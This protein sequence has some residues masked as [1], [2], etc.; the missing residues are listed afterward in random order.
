MI[1]EKK[2][3]RFGNDFIVNTSTSKVECKTI[4]EFITANGKVLTETV[5]KISPYV[6]GKKVEVKTGI[7]DNNSIEIL[8]GVA[9]GDEVVP[10]PYNAINRTLKDSMQVR[11]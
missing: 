2:Q 8:E 5:V 7:Q 10:A 3:G 1:V 11:K 9:E 6:A 4:T